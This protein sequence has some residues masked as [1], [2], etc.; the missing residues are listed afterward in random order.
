MTNY[1]TAQGVQ[2]FSI[3]IGSGQ[4]N[5]TATINAVGSGA[6]IHYGG[7]NNTSSGNACSTIFQNVTLTNST[8][9]TA[10]RN[11]SAATTITLKGSIVD[12]DTTNLVRTIQYGTINIAGAA[13]TGTSSISSV[14]L[15]NSV[16]QHL[17][18]TSTNVS[19]QAQRESAVL[20]L[21]GSN[22]LA[23]RASSTGTLVIGYVVIEFQGSALNQAVQQVSASTIT[24]TTSFTAAF[25]S[26]TLNNS[27]AFF[28]GFTDSS[29]DSTNAWN[30]RG[31]LSNS[32]TL[33]ATINSGSLATH[34]FNV[35]I[36][37]LNT[38]VLN[39]SIQRNTTSLSSSSSNTT[40]ITSVNSAYAGLNFLQN[41]NNTAGTGTASKMWM[42][43][44]L[45]SNTVITASSFSSMGATASWEIF[46]F[47][48]PITSISFDAT[49]AS[50]YQA[51][52]SSYSWG[53]TCSG[54]NRFLIVGISL[55][56]VAQTVTGITYAG[57]A[58]TFIGARNAATAVRTELW[59]LI[60][61]AT[62]SNNI[63]VTLSGSIASVGCAASYTN[64]D[65]TT[66]TEDYVSAQATNIGA[67]DATVTLTTANDRDWVVSM[68][69]TTAAAP[70]IGSGDTQR[71]N[72]N[73]A[74]GTGALGD[75][76]ADV[77]P[78][79][80]NTSSWSNI[81]AAAVWAIGAVALRVVGDGTEITID[82]VMGL[83]ILSS[84]RRDPSLYQEV[85]SKQMNDDTCYQE[86]KSSL[87]NDDN[88]YG[89][90]VSASMNDDK[91]F[92]EERASSSY[93][94][95]LQEEFIGAIRED[96]NIQGEFIGA[97]R[98]DKNLPDESLATDTQNTNF[99]LEAKASASANPN[100][101]EEYIAALKNDDIF[102]NEF[103]GAQKNDNNQ[104][105]ES[106]SAGRLDGSAQ[107]ETK[108]TLVVDPLSQLESRA[109][110]I[111]TTNDGLLQLESTSLLKNDYNVQYEAVIST[112]LDSVIT[113][114]II[115]KINYDPK[116][117][118]EIIGGNKTDTS[119]QIST[120]AAQTSNSNISDEA[121]SA[122]SIDPL[123]QIELR[124]GIATYASDSALQ[125]ES[126]SALKKD[127]LAANEY[128]AAARLDYTLRNEYL[129]SVA[130]NSGVP[131]EFL[132]KLS[133]DTS[134]L[135]ELLG[136]T[137][138]DNRVAEEILS[139]SITRIEER[140][141]ALIASLLHAPIQ[142]ES[143]LLT[144]TFR[145][146]SVL[147]FEWVSSTIRDG[148]LGIEIFNIPVTPAGRVLDPAMQLR[149]MDP[150]T[151]GRIIDPENNSRGL[152]PNNQSRTFTLI[153]SKRTL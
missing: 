129:A 153:V 139:G 8:T 57:T 90:F 55:L 9:I 37:E 114:E 142:L 71:Q 69:A 135:I 45:T 44:T 40:G 11:S 14:T 117:L 103:T 18:W 73:G 116:A 143:L 7:Q 102:L 147:Q 30:T 134:S 149:V 101:G 78:P 84:A 109:S 124:S 56:S 67:A 1:I 123:V 50:S 122:Q 99:T 131:L 105:L 137:R 62:G 61:P 36:V 75:T 19:L 120:Y 4:S 51:A 76:N 33:T 43:A 32:T 63:A 118:S 121:L 126:L 68:L 93:N 74:A 87:I 15:A 112:K 12:A 17:G 110:V 65:Q 140:L 81:G 38:G 108:A 96:S 49:S 47:A 138:S 151:M 106:Q 148:D 54:S 24:N 150:E 20:T 22:I 125:L 34:K 10:S 39:S 145:A 128:L 152:S 72:V 107:Q 130:I 3:T 28:S 21:T 41:T 133:S 94:P 70:T 111:T 89:E 80:S 113:E 144:V 104:R 5:G 35:C 98:L 77:T 13:T 2:N 46:E 119:L 25:S 83:C 58:L 59:G 127:G 92:F 146:D 136:S 53:H 79:G 52:S 27:L 48:A 82:S 16:V 26:V 85:L 31:S 100:F 23:T 132:N 91:I 95:N 29:A 97:A 141:E 115:G 88:I 64:V 60:A 66:A 6:Y 42:N 86:F